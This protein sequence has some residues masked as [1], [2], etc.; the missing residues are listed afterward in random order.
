MREI[1]FSNKAAREFSAFK[2]KEQLQFFKNFELEDKQIAEADFEENKEIQKIP[3]RSDYYRFRFGDFRIYFEFQP[4][5]IHILRVLKKNTW[6]DFT[7]RAFNWE[8]E[9]LLSDL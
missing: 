7:F 8:N 2:K 3:N 5:K 6:K 9:P 4:G 1:T